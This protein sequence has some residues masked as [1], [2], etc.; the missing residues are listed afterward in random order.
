M[1]ALEHIFDLNYIPAVLEDLSA[2]HRL[3]HGTQ[4]HILGI[5]ASSHGSSTDHNVE[6]LDLGRTAEITHTAFIQFQVPKIYCGI[7]ER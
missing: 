7:A 6:N 4:S 2:L 5:L 1:L 3:G